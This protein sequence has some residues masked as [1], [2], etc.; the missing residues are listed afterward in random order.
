LE[1]ALEVVELA[2]RRAI[3]VRVQVME[4]IEGSSG[5]H[6]DIVSLVHVVHLR[7]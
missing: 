1:T 3:A 4:K 6:A 5:G 2:A 7:Q